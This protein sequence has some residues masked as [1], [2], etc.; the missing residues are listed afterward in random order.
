MEIARKHTGRKVVLKRGYH[1]WHPEWQTEDQNIYPL[2]YEWIGEDV[3]AVILEPVICDNSLENRVSVEEVV[4]AAREVGAVVIF[5][6]VVTGVRFPKFCVTNY[7]NVRPDLICLGKALG[8]GLPLACVAGAA[9]LM[10]ND[11]YFVSSTFGGDCA[12]LTAM[13]AVF[14]MLSSFDY[15]ISRL[16]QFGQKVLDE[17]NSIDPD[18]IR[19]EGYPTR[20]VLAGQL[21]NEFMEVAVESGYLFGPSYFISFPHMNLDFMD[22]LRDIVWKTKS[23]KLKGMPRRMP[24]AQ[25]ARD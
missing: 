15:D 16:W 12:A 5:D 11:D 20:G 17:V 23:H 19:F 18:A 22:N 8:G 10:D 6:E 9:E 1:G 13:K 24:I 3:A 14:S 2:I 4:K 25:K 21:V 7:W